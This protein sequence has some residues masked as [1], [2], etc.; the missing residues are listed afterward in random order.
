MAAWTVRARSAADMPVVTPSR[1]SMETVK[2][3]SKRDSFLA[4][5][6]SK[7]S[8]PHRC[9]LRARQMRPLP[10]LAMK[11]MASGVANCAARVR[12]P[13][14][15]LPSSSHTTTIRPCRMSSSASSIEAN[16]LLIEGSPL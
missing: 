3:V 2:A 9:E 13:S 6:R 16:G 5:M 8:S 11:L 4:A 15:S 1:A 7:P 10:S 12:S 14:F